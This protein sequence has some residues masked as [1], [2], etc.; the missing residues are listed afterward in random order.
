MFL[1][2]DGSTF[3]PSGLLD[4]PDRSVHIGL[5]SETSIDFLE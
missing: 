4:E 2:Q 1:F 5:K 3:D